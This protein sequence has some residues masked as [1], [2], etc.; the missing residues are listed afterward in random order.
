MVGGA[1]STPAQAQYTT[2]LSKILRY[3]DGSKLT[4]QVD[5]ANQR[6]EENLYDK[7]GALLWKLVREL[8]EDL[9]PMR[10]IKFDARDQIISRHKY[11]CL[12]GRVEEEEI[13]DAK[14]NLRARL[15]YFY[16]AKGRINRIDHHNAAG[17]LV[18]SSRAS[19]TPVDPVL[20]ENKSPA[21]S[22][23]TPPR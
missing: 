16:D 18:S 8:D 23:A 22:D 20:R 15:V 10:A 14:N 5:T 19:G 17:K 3:D 21:G 9:Q 11:L 7:S 6:V 2:P 4:V 1:L 13:L 12:R